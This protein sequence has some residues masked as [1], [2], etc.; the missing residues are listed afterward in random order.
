M[1]AQDA[2][3]RVLGVAIGL[4]KARRVKRVETQRMTRGFSM[5]SDII[6]CPRPPGPG[7]HVF[8]RILITGGA[9]FVGSSLALM[10]KRDRA[11]VRVCALRQPQAPR[12]RARARAAAGAGVEFVHGDV[13]SPDDLADAGAFDLLLECS[14]EPSVHAGYDGSPSYVLQTNLT[15]TINCL[16]AARRHRRRRHLSLDEPRLSDRRPARAAARAPRAAARHA[17]GRVR[18]RVVAH[19]ASPRT[20]R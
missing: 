1:R 6:A 11:D 5:A 14:A 15:G 2:P 13:R 8:M 9:G 3:D 10:L 18:A 7:G 4:G 12:Q 17:R 19:A 20:S 16:E